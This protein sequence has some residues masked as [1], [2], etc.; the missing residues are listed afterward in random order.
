[1]PKLK[2]KFQ[3]LE[4]FICIWLVSIFATLFWLDGYEGE[5]GT[6]KSR[7]LIVAAFAM[8]VSACNNSFEIA[9]PADYEGVDPLLFSMQSPE[10]L[11]G[12]RCGDDGKKV[13]ICHVPPG[14]PDAKHT[15]CIGESA[16]NAHLNKHHGGKSLDYLGDCTPVPQPTA[17]PTPAPTT[18][19]GT[20]PTPGPVVNPTPVPTTSPDPDYVPDPTPVPTTDPVATPVPVVDPTP[21]PVVDPTPMPTAMP[22][23]SPVPVVDPTPVPVVD[24]TPAP[25]PAPTPRPSPMP[26]NF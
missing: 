14:N 4:A 6:M 13:L 11:A 1:V 9:E 3:T 26:D 22:Q 25:T 18:A 2:T 19:P 23:P 17:E 24:P 16:V 8:T 15:I 21:V 5:G 20:D 12:F 7:I 10:A